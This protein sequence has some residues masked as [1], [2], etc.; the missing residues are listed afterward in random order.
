MRQVEAF[1]FSLQEPR[2]IE[3][4]STILSQYYQISSMSCSTYCLMVAV[5]RYYTADC[6]RGA[7]E[8]CTATH[9]GT[10]TVLAPTLNHQI[11]CPEESRAGC[12][13]SP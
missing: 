6:N 10:L 12:R 9:L 3:R 11:C 8:I 13:L 7:F 1:I 4:T 2:T 5:S